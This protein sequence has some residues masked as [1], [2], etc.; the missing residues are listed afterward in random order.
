MRSLWWEEDRLRTCLLL[1]RQERTQASRLPA[2]RKVNAPP[3][4]FGRIICAAKR[5]ARQARRSDLFSDDGMYSYV[6]CYIQGLK[7]VCIMSFIRHMAL[8]CSA[9]YTYKSYIHTCIIAD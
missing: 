4:I 5:Q 9:V 1:T 7:P 6:C 2:I 3:L 8:C